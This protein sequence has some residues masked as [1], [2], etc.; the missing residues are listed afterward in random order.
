MG[1]GVAAS[2]GVFSEPEI[3]EFA[4][5]PEDKFLVCASDGVFEF[6]SNEDIVKIVV[7]FWKTNDVQGACDAVAQE[8]RTRWTTVSITQEEEVIDDITCV[9]VFLDVL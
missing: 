2:V 4:L 7:P 3:L 6:L 5:T 1:D 8:A 9:I